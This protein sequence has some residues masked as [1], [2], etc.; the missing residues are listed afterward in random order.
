M[1]ADVAQELEQRDRLGPVALSTSVAWNGPG[2]KSSE[3]GQLGL[4]ALDV[5]GEGLDVEQ[6]AFLGATA[7]IAD[8]ARGAAGEWRSG[9]ARRAGSGAADAGR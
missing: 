3:A 5:V 4:D 8:H 6:V 9:G 7:R 2:S 1:L